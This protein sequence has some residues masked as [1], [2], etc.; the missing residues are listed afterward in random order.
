MTPQTTAQNLLLWGAALALAVLLSFLSGIAT[1]WPDGG[2]IDWR[3]V[4]LDVIQTILTTAPDP[5]LVAAARAEA[6]G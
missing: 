1:H 4:A 5:K 2:Q 6:S 3:G